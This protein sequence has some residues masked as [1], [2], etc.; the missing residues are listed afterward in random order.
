VR[1]VS[2]NWFIGP[3]HLGN[4]MRRWLLRVPVGTLRLHHILRSDADR[5]MHDHPFD[6]TS[7]ILTGGYVEHRPGCYC[8]ALRGAVGRHRRLARGI[9]RFYGPGSI[10]RR[11]AE[12]LHRLELVDGPTWTV[13]ISG[14]YRRMWGFLTDTGW[15][16]YKQYMA[17]RHH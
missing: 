12:D 1:R 16:P 6:F 9:C 15:V 8:E 4:Y 2:R 10:V 11:R 17:G 13:V 3:D 5:H 7:L 14:R